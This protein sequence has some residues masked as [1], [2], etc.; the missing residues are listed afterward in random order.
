MSI[1]DPTWPTKVPSDR[2]RGG[3][4]EN[5]AVL[6]IAPAHPVLDRER[7]AFAHRLSMCCEADLGVVGVNVLGPA[8]AQLL[9]ERPAREA[10]PGL[11]D[12]GALAI[13][14]R[15]TNEDRG[16]VGHGAEALLG[17]G[18]L[19]LRPHLTEDAIDGLGQVVEVLDGLRD[20]VA[21]PVRQ[22]DHRGLLPKPVTRITGRSNPASRTACRTPAHPRRRAGDSRAG[23]G[24]PAC[25]EVDPGLPA[26][27]AVRRRSRVPGGDAP[28]WRPRIILHDQD[29]S[30][31]N[32]GHC[33]LLSQA[34]AS[35]RG[36]WTID[37]NSPSR[38]TASMNSS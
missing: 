20:E 6:A 3:R 33:G 26:V 7:D 8:V 19:A 5:P 22:L 14:I 25:G 31:P 28:A 35:S 21:D 38:L 15:D 24:P 9:I 30:Q 34:R 37:R 11:I 18:E 1:A 10:Q 13:G 27:A 12:E 29:R 2:I 16:M 23:S 4:V 32:V 36:T 17:L